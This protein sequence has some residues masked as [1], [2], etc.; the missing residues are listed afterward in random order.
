VDQSADLSAVGGDPWSDIW[1]AEKQLFPGAK[2]TKPEKKKK[3]SH[4]SLS[5]YEFP[6]II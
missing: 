1:L 3:N 2:S 5:F 4:C 6:Y